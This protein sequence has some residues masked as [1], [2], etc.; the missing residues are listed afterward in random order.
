MSNPL[1]IAGVTA[2]LEYCLNLVYNNPSAVLGGVSVSALAPDIVQ[3]NFVNGSSSQLHV[4]LFLHQVAHNAAWRNVR[5]PSLSADGSTRLKNPPLAL[6]LH[7]LLTAYAS[8]DTQAEAL[9][10]FAVLMLHENAVLPRSQI[11]TA[12][13]NLPSTNPL[14]S[15]LSSS[16]LAE[17]IEMIKITP[18]A[19]GREE[20]A[21]LWTALKADY[22]PT[23]C[24]QVSVVL[25]ESQL[26]SSPGL[27]V[28]SRTVSAQAMP[29]AQFGSGFAQLLAIQLPAGQS[30]PIQGD[31]VILSGSGLG[32]VTGVALSNQ[33]L[34]IQYSAPLLTPATD[35][36]VSFA[37][38]TDAD[39]LP[40]G[41]YSVAVT[42]TDTSGAPQSSNSL[43]MGV[44]PAIL[45][46]PAPVATGNASGILVMI[47]CNPKVQTTQS[48]SLALGSTA[49]PA[50]P[51]T[52]A[53]D[54]LSFQ[55]PAL[56]A[57]PYLARLQVDGAESP[58]SV[59]WSPPPPVFTGPFVTI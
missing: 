23:Y 15:V 17:Q 53:T 33:R 54:T 21:W 45:T 14:A 29:A 41:P 43:P 59:N 6:D 50:Q 42:Y 39:K 2:T 57:G 34:G 58:V 20:M 16:G 48:I 24:F 44:A 7:Y 1:A 3:T 19:L 25:I 5:L 9:L 30:S 38:P 37:V 46:T 26:A 55:F 56:A 35:S 51:L 47:T 40:A 13:S 10:G 28:L 22:R 32:T 52:T 18:A 12:L 36:S 4:N 27:P 31:T 11:N 49:V 8:E